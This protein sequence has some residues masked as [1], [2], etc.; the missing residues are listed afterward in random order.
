MFEAMVPLITMKNEIMG[1]VIYEKSNDNEVR[2]NWY[3][4]TLKQDKEIMD[5]EIMDK[6]SPRS[7]TKETEEAENK[8]LSYP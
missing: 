5:K 1:A 3:Q 2:L 8:G 4:A 7:E 6:E